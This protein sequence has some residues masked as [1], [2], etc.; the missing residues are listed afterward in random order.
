MTLDASLGTSRRRFGQGLLGAAAIG[1]AGSAKA[2]YASGSGRY[3]PYNCTATTAINTGFLPATNYTCKPV[4]DISLLTLALNLEY[5]EASFYLYATTGVGLVAGDK[6]GTPGNVFN[7][8][9]A[10]LSNAVVAAYAQELAAEERQHVET[11]R[12]RIIALNMVPVSL[13][14][15]DFGAGF[16]YVMQQAGIVASGATF[17]AFAND[18]NF[19]L[20]AYV[21]EDLLVSA[22]RGA[23]PFIANPATLDFV[24]G[25]LGAEGYHAGILRALLFTMGAGSTTNAISHVRSVLD[26]TVGTPAQGNDHGVGTL[27][28]PSI[29]NVDGSAIVEGRTTQQIVNITFDAAT[30]TSPTLGLPSYFFPNGLSSP[31]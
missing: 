7:A 23:I 22:Y 1:A 11:L 13:P 20:A 16:S 2:Q 29:A 26:G 15:I 28:G 10:T 24:G 12:N 14:N 21:L 6:G 9:Q 31:Y 3:V 19:L 27:T 8:R 18:G 25:L 17:D 5:L 30:Q 4:S